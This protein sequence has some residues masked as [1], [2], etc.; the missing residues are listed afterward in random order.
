MVPEDGD[1]GSGQVRKPT[2]FTDVTTHAPTME[3]YA[4][5]AWK[6][7]ADDGELLAYVAQIDTSVVGQ[8]IGLLFTDQWTICTSEGD[9]TFLIHDGDMSSMLQVTPKD[10]DTAYVQTAPQRLTET[11][12]CDAG[13]G[14]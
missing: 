2:A 11:T 4:V 6:Q 9:S 12:Q 3:T 14:D 13:S 10:A 5:C 7:T 1:S 8:A